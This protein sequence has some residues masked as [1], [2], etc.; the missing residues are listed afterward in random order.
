MGFGEYCDAGHFARYYGGRKTFGVALGFFKFL[1]LLLFDF[2]ISTIEWRNAFLTGRIL[3]GE[4]TR[5]IYILFNYRY[6]C[7]FS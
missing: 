3:G 7:R 6:S 2:V 5:D 4:A 1:V